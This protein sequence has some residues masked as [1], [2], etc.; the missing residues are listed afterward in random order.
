MCE[1]HCCSMTLIVTSEDLEPE[2]VTNALGWPPDQS[3]RRGERKRLKRPDGTA[4]IFDSVH[5][6]GAWKLFQA[7]EARRRSLEDQ[8]AEWLQRLR[9]KEG[10]L[11]A[12]RDRGWE[13][14]LDCFVATSEYLEL[15]VTVM[16]EL[17]G[18]GVGLALTFS[19]DAHAGDANVP[20]K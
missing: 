16:G 18:F 15:P 19:A 7:D 10:A 9:A 1:E 5:E 20:P 4:R 17:A 11:R 2:A 8:F 6:S 12:L 3:W 13:I 14:E